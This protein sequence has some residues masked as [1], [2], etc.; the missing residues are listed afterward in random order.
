MFTVG[1]S[2]I[3]MSFFSAGSMTI[4]LFTT[5]Q[6][7]AWLATIWKG[8]PVPTAS[9]YYAVGSVVM[10][11]IGGLSGVFTGVIPV[12]WQAHNTYYVVAHIHYVLIGAN[13]FPV[14]AGFYYW[15]PKMTGRMMN[16][17][18]GK[19]SFWVMFIGFNV[20]FFPMHILGLLGMPRRIYT[21]QSGLGYDGWNM[22]VTVGAFVLGLG[23]LISIVN[24][25]VSLR[26]G[27]LAGANP[28]NSDGLEW[29]TSSPPE[30][31]E[32]VH[33]PLVAS[34][35]PLWDDFIEEED[36]EDD[37]TLHGGRLTPTT[38]VLDAIP[39]GIA[40]I[41]EDS[42]VP[43]LMSIAMFAFFVVF[44]FKMLWGALAMLLVTFLL[45]CIWMWPRTVK[46]VL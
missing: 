7:F 28:W 15:L 40:T 35:H 41:P 43:L 3:A 42:I 46:E 12:D 19:L 24:L 29:G 6:V 25:V 4:S 27:V 39:I 13:V 32:V 2:D 14:F 11:V 45:G 26:S 30:P 10:L 21:Y 33:I 9:M 36:A 22:V 44:V 5:I 37:R 31:Y 18:L 8:R 1:M 38:T 16:E 20:G 17:R 34:R 23:I